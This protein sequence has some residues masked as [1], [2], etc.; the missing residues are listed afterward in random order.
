MTDEHRL[1]H[2]DWP[3]PSQVHAIITTR[4]GG[5]SRGAFQGLNLASHVGDDP[6]KVA[7][8]R[9]ELER[10]ANLPSQPVWLN[11]THSTQVIAADSNI[12]L[13]TEHQSGVQKEQQASHHNNS[14]TALDADASVSSSSNVVCCVLTADCLPIL[15]TNQQGDWVAAI[16]AGWRGLLNGIIENTLSQYSSSTHELLAWLGPAISQAKFEVGA[17]VRQMFLSQN[18]SDDV[19]FK[20]SGEKYLADLYGIAR[21]KLNQQHVDVY[22]G[23]YCTYQQ[24]ELFYSYRRDG[25]TGRMASLIWFDRI[26]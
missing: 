6:K 5:S 16:H 1:T 4:V 20:V 13:L 21:R 12:G 11:Q 19:F 7:A 24:P 9:L 22:G 17:E 26:N 15:L 25:E 3:V 18:A 14:N 2:P 10:L 8:N 23:D